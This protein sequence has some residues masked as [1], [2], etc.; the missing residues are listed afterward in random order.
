VI[1]ANPSGTLNSEPGCEAA[2]YSLKIIVRDT[3]LLMICFTVTTSVT[4]PRTQI[5]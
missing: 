4:P 2:L 3:R 5:I 1:L